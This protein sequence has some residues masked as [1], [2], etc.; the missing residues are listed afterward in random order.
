MTRNSPQNGKRISASP[1][2]TQHRRARC[3]WTLLACFVL[4]LSTLES[5]LLRPPRP[6]WWRKQDLYLLRVGYEFSIVY[7]PR[8]THY[9]RRRPHPAPSN[10]HLGSAEEA[11]SRSL[12]VH[13]SGPHD[14]PILP[15]HG[16]LSSPASSDPQRHL[17]TIL[18]MPLLP[19]ERHI[20]HIN[21]KTSS[22][23]H[24]GL[25]SS[26]SFI[27]SISFPFDH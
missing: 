6:G 26:P 16:V 2:V 12:L 15:Y 14:A 19:D 22:L 9:A 3:A 1:H 18:Y 20:G 4:A 24:L 23:A 25:S 5:S 11:R 17:K 7:S 21:Y 13:V 10:T 27:I 8:T